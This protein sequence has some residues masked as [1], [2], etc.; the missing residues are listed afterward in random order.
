MKYKVL[1]QIGEYAL[2]ETDTQYI[3]ACGY[4]GT[5]PEGQQWGYG[6]YFTHWNKSETEKAH[7]FYGAIETFKE[8]TEENYI[9]RSRLEE[10]TMQFKDGLIE[11]DAADAIEYFDNVCKMTEEE[12]EWF[13]IEGGMKIIV[14]DR[15]TSDN[16]SANNLGDFVYCCNCQQTMLIDIGS[17]KCSECEEETLMWADENNQEVDESFFS[18]N[19][20]YI[21]VDVE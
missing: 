12:K 20:N 2:I 13:G 18:K 10:L 9:P 15:R 8:K 3:V 14:L 16:Q 5:Q 4:D 11:D 6:L 19:D 21:L 1:L 7:M 17:L